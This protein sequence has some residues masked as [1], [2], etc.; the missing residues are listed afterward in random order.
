MLRYK[1]LITW[2]EWPVGAW[3]GTRRAKDRV[4]KFLQLSK[5]LNAWLR[6]NVG[7]STAP[8]DSRGR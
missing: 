8:P 1:G 5:P 7:P 3:L 6:A 2:Q 4:E